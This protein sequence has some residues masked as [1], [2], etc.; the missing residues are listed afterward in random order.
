LSEQLPT[1]DV[2]NRPWERPGVVRRDCEPHRG[3]LLSVL[4]G[5][6]LAVAGFLACIPATGFLALPLALVTF[7]LARRDLVQ[8]RVGCMDPT[9]QRQTRRAQYRAGVALLFGGWNLLLTVGLVI[10]LWLR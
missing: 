2:D 3:P 5:T 7:Y 9:G 6:S 10:S 8:M 4:G 1:N